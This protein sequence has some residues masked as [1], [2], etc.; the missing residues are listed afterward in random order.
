MKKPPCQGCNERYPVCHSDCPKYLSWRKGYDK[1]N[2]EINAN[3][4]LYY[5]LDDYERQT[6]HKV[7]KGK[8][9]KR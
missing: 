7:W 2:D 8:G 1:E 3:K 5:S 4:A 9:K 6:R